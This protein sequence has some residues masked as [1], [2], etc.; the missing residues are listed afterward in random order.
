MTCVSIPSSQG[1][2]KASQGRLNPVEIIVLP[3]GKS[4]DACAEIREAKKGGTSEEVKREK[5]RKKKPVVAKQQPVQEQTDMFEFL[6]TKIF[7]KGTCW[8]L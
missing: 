8:S 5:K 1:L 2:G 7:N 4:L 3:P 6:N